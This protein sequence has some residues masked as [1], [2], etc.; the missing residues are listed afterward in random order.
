MTMRRFHARVLQRSALLLAALL[1]LWFGL[2]TSA[3][4]QCEHFTPFGQPVHRSLG[5]DVGVNAPPERT[6]ICHT[7]QV[8]AF[9][10]AHN[11][12]DWVAHRLRRED[13]LNDVVKRKDAFRGDPEVPE[14][15]RAVKADYTGTGYDRGHLAPAGA[16]KWSVEAMSESFFMSNMAPQVGNGF[17]RHI[18]KSLEQRM[19]RWACERGVLYVVTG[20]LYEERP[21]EQL[22]Y[23]KDGDGVDDNGVLVDVPSHF[24]KLAYDPARVEAIA[25]LLPNAKLETKDLPEFLHSIDDIED[26]ARLDV[27]PMI[28][29]GAE[30]AI[31]NHK[32]PRLWEKPQRADCAALG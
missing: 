15:H 2:T 5:D 22:V 3:S 19:R 16:M 31:E 32:Q 24:F 26:R 1:F 7:G 8:V 29:D 12:S 4:A 30:E 25:F 6:V 21:I 20:P 13:L 14:E 10:P 17:N 9:N 28:W 27:L 23:D 18:W 11:V